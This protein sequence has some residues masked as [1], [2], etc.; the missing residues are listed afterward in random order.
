[1]NQTMEMAH[2]FA[3]N[4]HD[5]VVTGEVTPESHSNIQFIQMQVMKV[6]EHF[7]LVIAVNYI[8]YINELE[9]YEITWDKSLFVVH[10]H[11]H[12]PWWRGEELPDNGAA[13]F[14]DPRMT[15]V[16]TLSEAHKKSYL[17]N[18]P[19]A[20]KKAK[21][22]ANAL[23]PADW[24]ASGVEKVS[25]RFIF[26]SRN[27]TALKVLRAIWPKIRTEA[28]DATLVIA[29]P[30]YGDDVNDRPELE[31]VNYVGSL[32]T[33]RLRQ[34]IMAAEYWI[35]PSTYAEEYGLTALE[36]MMGNVKVISTTKG[37]L[38]K[39]IP[40]HGFEIH[41]NDMDMEDATLAAW[42]TCR[43]DTNGT[44]KNLA[45][46]RA[47][48]EAQSWDVRLKEWLEIIDETPKAQCKHSRTLLLF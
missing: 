8:H 13:L 26:T 28:S 21:V 33:I 7:D 44:E 2:I 14:H 5:I 25:N 18:N 45:A 32:S 46:A 35:N 22:I 11:N 27:A 20:S 34:E 38:S 24:A 4:G 19:G 47:F 12:Y 23:K 10:H 42:R 41:D 39:L 17:K 40:D 48:A 3:A 16:I 9:C 15:W 37:N 6:G 1:M 31:G 36:M 43:E 29:D 30:Y